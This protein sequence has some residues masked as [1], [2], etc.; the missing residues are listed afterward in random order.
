MSDQ[1]RDSYDAMSEL[2]VAVNRGALDGEGN[3]LREWLARFAE[4]AALGDSPVADLGCGPGFVTQHL[5]ELG[6]DMRGF[7]LSP[8]LIAEAQSMFPELD[9][10]VADFTALDLPDASFAGILTRYSLIHSQ[11]SDL[12]STF[13]EFGRLLK[14]DAPIHVSFFAA[15][16]AEEHGTPFDHKVVTA[17]ALFPA[18]IAGELERAGFDR[19][20]VDVIGPRQGERQLDH[21][22]IHARRS[23]VGGVASSQVDSSMP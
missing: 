2:Y 22:I 19:L 3:R 11:P 15:S 23:D 20:E 9:V 4:M 18:T 8:A 12:A 16:S 7:D 17:Y 13:V 14:P 10:Q 6:L 1:I 5:T 21:A